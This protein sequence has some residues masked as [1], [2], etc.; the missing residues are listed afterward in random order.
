MPGL[1]AFPLLPHPFSG[2]QR[3]RINVS[4]KENL[5]AMATRKSQ[6]IN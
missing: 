3:S 4:R 1:S 2:P 6:S 5:S